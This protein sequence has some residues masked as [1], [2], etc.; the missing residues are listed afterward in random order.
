MGLWR[1]GDPCGHWPTRGTRRRW[2]SFAD[3]AE[4]RGDV[5][6]LNELLDEGCERAGEHPTRRAV[7]ASDLLELQRI[8]DAG[9]DE[10]G[11]ELDRLL[12]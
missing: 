2:T 1:T 8:R 10:A 7:A 6:A 5:D 11:D 9:Y 12:D 4:E 3:L